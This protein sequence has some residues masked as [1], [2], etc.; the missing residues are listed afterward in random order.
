MRSLACAT[1]NSTSIHPLTK[2]DRFPNCHAPV[3]HPKPPRVA[4]QWLGAS[5]EKHMDWRCPSCNESVPATFDL[6]WNCGQPEQTKNPRTTVAA[7][8]S[9]VQQNPTNAR[10]LRRCFRWLLMFLTGAAALDLLF[11][12]I[13]RFS[14]LVGIQ[15]LL[16]PL[17]SIL[18]IYLFGT[19][20]H[21]PGSP[22]R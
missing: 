21:E 14:I 10:A 18:F 3:R 16:A 13:T 6:C 2:L 1:F 22:C 9:S 7:S 11:H 15:L 17:L 5:R 12:G 8:E 20:T 19:T 4:G